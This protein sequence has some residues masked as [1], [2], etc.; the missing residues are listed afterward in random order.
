MQ[1]SRMNKSYKDIFY[2]NNYLIL[3]NFIES[4]RAE[5]LYKQFKEDVKTNPQ[6]FLVD[7]QC[8]LS[9]SIYNYKPFLNI[10]CEKI[11]D[12][13]DVM[14]E[15]MLPTY[16]YARIYKNNEILEKHVDRPSCEISITLHLGGDHEWPIWMTKPNGEE[17]SIELKPGQAVMYNGVVS[18]HWRDKFKG[19]EYGQVFLHYVRGEGIY[20]EHY[21][22][23]S[24][25]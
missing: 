1:I 8:P 15:S 22:D 2:S 20:W 3:N 13:S 11:K 21:G 4:K 24:N 25:A 7:D 9:F 17:V 6:F 19:F 12:V 10:L 18:T 23:R 14:E 16:T 5:E